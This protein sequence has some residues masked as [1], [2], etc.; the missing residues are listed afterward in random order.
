MTSL[1]LFDLDGTI[2]DTLKDLALSV[3]YSLSSENL[4]SRTTD[5]IRTFLGNGIRVLINLS[6]PENTSK[7]QTERVFKTFVKYY[8]EHCVDNTCPFE[9]IPEL[10]MALRKE[11][12]KIAIVSNKADFAAQKLCK[13]FFPDMYD[14]A[15]GAKDGIAKKPARDMI[16]EALA[17]FP[18]IEEKDCVYIGDSE[19]D[20]ETA[21]NA[22]MREIAVLWGFR[23]LEE[24]KKSG[25]VDFAADSKELLQKI[26][27]K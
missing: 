15:I 6:V 18:E 19:V 2:L 14:F 21:R 22:K 27:N 17:A 13:Q 12:V 7:E 11:G 9:G 20:V 23:S 26:L 8:G 25:A 10:F 1:A 3:N 4:P 16:D 5:E 24:L